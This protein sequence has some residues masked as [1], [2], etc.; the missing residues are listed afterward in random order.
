MT[1]PELPRELWDLIAHHG[2]ATR[3]QRCVRRRQSRYAHTPR[4]RSVRRALAARLLEV[5][6][7]E[8]LMK[9]EWVRREWEQEPESWLY[10]LRH[11]THA[12]DEIVSEVL[13]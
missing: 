9:C 8:A 6:A 7:W 3:V 4:W 13:T 5:R 2:A 11:E 10:M 1:V 12:L